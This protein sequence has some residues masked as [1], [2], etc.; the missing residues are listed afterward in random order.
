MDVEMSFSLLM[1]GD[2]ELK[3]Q[4][5]SKGTTEPYNYGLRIIP[6]EKDSGYFPMLKQDLFFSILEMRG[7]NIL[8]MVDEWVLSK[9]IRVLLNLNF[10]FKKYED[11]VYFYERMPMEQ[12]V[13]YA[14]LSEMKAWQPPK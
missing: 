12:R 5:F 14:P 2:D 10:E 8:V 6:H 11:G 13:F 7:P 1:L 9:A 4:G 3:E